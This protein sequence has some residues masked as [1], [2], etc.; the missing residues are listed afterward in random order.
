MNAHIKGEKP[1][2][3]ELCGFRSVTRKTLK[4][5]SLLHYESA[6][7]LLC[8]ACGDVFK[9][10]YD[11]KQHK[12]HS[13]N[14]RLV[15]RRKVKS[16]SKSIS[17]FICEK[18]GLHFIDQQKY[19]SHIKFSHISE[20]DK[21]QC[22]H[23]PHKSMT[24]FSLKMHLALHYPPTLPCEKCGKLFHTKLYLTRLECVI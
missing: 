5:H 14:Q 12:K 1:Y 4:K 20:E 6:T 8:N 17:E 2:H 13:H 22:P 7:P 11:L 9:C 19:N 15:G 24:Q 16:K 10:Q 23:C 3:C 21:L 18:C